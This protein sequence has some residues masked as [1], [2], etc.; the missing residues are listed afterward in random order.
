MKRFVM[1]AVAALAAFPGSALAQIQATPDWRAVSF[2]G[3]GDDEGLALIDVASLRRPGETQREIRAATV[4]KRPGQLAR[5]RSFSMTQVV[6]RFDCKGMTYAPLRTEAWSEKGRVM[7]GGNEGAVRK[8]EGGTIMADVREIVCDGLFNHLRKVPGAN[9]IAPS[10]ELI[11]QRQSL[12]D[13]RGRSGWQ[14]LSDSG[15]T[16]DRLQYFAER[17]SV[18]SD[19]AGRKLVS[20]MMLVEKTEGGITRIHYLVRVDCKARTGETIYAE[21]FGSDGRA[22][23]EILLNSGPQPLEPGRMAAALE[24]PVCRGDWNTGAP[25][26]RSPEQ[27]SREAF[28]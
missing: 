5:G 15:D 10:L 27:L 16:P 12:I 2:V 22:L 18:I 23:S 8:I 11:A 20:T 9:P 3:R 24:V 17:G 4:T 1:L 26:I 13:S 7:G 14:R 21:A 6:Y 25:E 19:S 28:R